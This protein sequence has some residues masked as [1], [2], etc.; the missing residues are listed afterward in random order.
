MGLLGAGNRSRAAPLA[1]GAAC[2]EANVTL[3]PSYAS[4]A[5]PVAAAHQGL[6]AAKWGHESASVSGWCRSGPKATTG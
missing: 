1:K 3:P 5:Y 6:K 2:A 4:R